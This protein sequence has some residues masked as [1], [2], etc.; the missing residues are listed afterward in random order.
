MLQP[1]LAPPASCLASPPPRCSRRLTPS[2]E[3][4][5]ATVQTLTWDPA[6]SAR[7]AH[8]QSK[9]RAQ[10]DRRIFQ[11]NRAGLRS[12]LQCPTCTFHLQ[13]PISAASSIQGSPL[14]AAR[15]R[16]E[17]PGIVPSGTDSGRA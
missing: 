15:S 1:S 5:R 7:W 6:V 10:K 11:A 16:S 9:L 13:I 4:R 2:P 12:N 8:R 17:R 3:Q 14:G